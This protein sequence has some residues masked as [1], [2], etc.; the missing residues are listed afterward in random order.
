MIMHQP[1][2]HASGGQVIPMVVLTVLGVIGV[3]VG[4]VALLF[5]PQRPARAAPPV[6]SQ[7]SPALAAP[8]APAP[9]MPVVHTPSVGGAGL[10]PMAGQAR[11]P[12]S[13]REANGCF[14]FDTT[15]NGMTMRMMFDTGAS[16]VTLTTEDAARAGIAVSGLN[17][18]GISK[19]ANGTAE[20]AYVVLD[21]LKVGGITRS[22]VPALVSRPGKLST[23]LLG[24]SFMSKLN[25]YRFEGN[26]LILQGD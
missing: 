9:P 1:R 25:G 6:P 26:E 18:S 3:A 4:I 23:S 20:V 5:M 24:Q 15:V 17:Y 8:Q 19:T 13:K 2:R 10:L 11:Q 12:S 16:F 21:S 22:K 7:A 14:F